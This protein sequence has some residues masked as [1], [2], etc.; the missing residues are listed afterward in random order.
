[1]VETALMLTVVLLVLM[2]IIE[3]G[4]LFYAHVRISNAAREG[5]RA[6]SLWLLHREFTGPPNDYYDPVLCDTVQ[7]AV[8]AEFAAIEADDISITLTGG[9]VACPDTAL[10]PQAGQPIT[11]TVSYDYILPVAS[12]LPVI[13]DV[14]ASPFPVLR[15]TVMRFQ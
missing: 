15:A 2:G 4:L 9:D 10:A 13:R 12:G 8:Q 14:I 11:V 1:M 6:G 7:D 3:F 5:A